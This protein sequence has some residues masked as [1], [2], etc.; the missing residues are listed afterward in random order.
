[1]LKNSVNPGMH[2]VEVQAF[3]QLPASE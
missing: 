2:I 3:S 1:M